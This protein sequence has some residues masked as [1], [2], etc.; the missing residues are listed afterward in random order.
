MPAWIQWGGS[1]PED[2]LFLEP[3]DEEVGDGGEK[4]THRGSYEVEDWQAGAWVDLF[5]WAI[6]CR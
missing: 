2:L 6:P 3:G 5:L 1:N 4:I